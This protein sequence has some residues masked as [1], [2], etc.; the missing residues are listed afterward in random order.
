MILNVQKVQSADIQKV[1]KQYFVDDQLTV[2]ILDPQPM[3]RGANLRAAP[4]GMRH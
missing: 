1:V 4:A 2:A 3:K